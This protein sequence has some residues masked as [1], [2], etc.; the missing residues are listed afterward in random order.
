MRSLRQL[1]LVFRYLPTLAS[2]RQM[3]RLLPLE[4]TLSTCAHKRL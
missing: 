3:E 2:W 1:I 4:M